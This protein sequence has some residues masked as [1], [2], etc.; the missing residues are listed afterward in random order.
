MREHARDGETYNQI[1]KAMKNDHH[2]QWKARTVEFIPESKQRGDRCQ[3]PRW[4]RHDKLATQRHV[5]YCVDAQTSK[6]ES[7]LPCH[8]GQDR[9]SQR[10][11]STFSIRS[12]CETCYQHNW[13][14]LDRKRVRRMCLLQGIFFQAWRREQIRVGQLRKAACKNRLTGSAWATSASDSFFS[15]PS[16][17][18]KLI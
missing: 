11:L 2:E 14:G 8:L 18:V 9:R 6:V 7:R 4:A 17:M 15:S 13:C 16:T 3:T 5:M 1:K 10:N 12:V